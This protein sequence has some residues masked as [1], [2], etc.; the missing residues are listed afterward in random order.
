MVGPNEALLS[1]ALTRL[2]F[3]WSQFAI[4]LW[5]CSWGFPRAQ[6]RMDWAFRYRLCHSLLF[7]LR[8]LN[9][10]NREAC[11]AGTVVLLAYVFC[12]LAEFLFLTLP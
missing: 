2:Y 7:Q 4:L 6:I 1:K 10:I 3:P 11:A 12:L 5:H 8:I 9:P